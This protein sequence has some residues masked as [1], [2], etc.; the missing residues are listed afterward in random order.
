[1]KFICLALLG[2]AT[3]YAE[4]NIQEAIDSAKSGSVISIPA[5]TYRTP[6]SIKQGLTLSGE[7]AVL[8]VESNQPAILIDSYKTVLLK[9]LT[10]KY[11]TENKPQKGDTPYAVLIRN[12]DV[13]IKDCT[14]DALGDGAASPGAVS[15]QDK[16]EVEIS[17][18][19]FNGFEYTIQFWNGAEGDIEDCIIM[20]PG[21]CGIT[22]GNESSAELSQYHHRLAL[23]RYPMHRR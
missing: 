21:H 19:R 7:N 15:A 10:I 9:G 11:K 6:L 4:F 12:G 14:F 20:N 1:M 3:S 2:A 22:I 5:G 23:S 8:E 17:N 13:E 16:P 18:C